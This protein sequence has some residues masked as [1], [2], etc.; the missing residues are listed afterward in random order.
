MKLHLLSSK[1]WPRNNFSMW[2][3]GTNGIFMF[4]VFNSDAVVCFESLAMLIS[5]NIMEY[6]PHIFCFLVLCNQY[7]T[8][9]INSC[10]DTVSIFGLCFHLL[11]YTLLKSAGSPLSWDFFH[12]KILFRN[13]MGFHCYWNICVDKES[14]KRMSIS[15]HF[16]SQLVA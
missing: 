13:H 14:K 11:T 4:C 8:R 15:S 2:L 1:Q 3:T 9:T 7:S 6:F 12:W 10:D 5:V 16:R